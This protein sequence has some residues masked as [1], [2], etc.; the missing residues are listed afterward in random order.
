MAAAEKGSA[1]K[2][3][4]GKDEQGCANGKL[5]SSGGSAISDA[6]ARAASS[7]VGTSPATAS[8]LVT[9]L[10]AA[11]ATRVTAARAIVSL[12]SA[13]AD[14]AT[15]AANMSDGALATLSDGEIL[16]LRK[17]MSIK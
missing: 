12:L 17:C 7:T 6:A 14:D 1:S 16:L 3:G 4:E 10:V 13:L 2:G 8:P 5:N 15:P 11:I 9:G